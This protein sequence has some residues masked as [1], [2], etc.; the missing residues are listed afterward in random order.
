[1]KEAMCT[2]VILRRPGHDWPMILAANRDEMTDR[3]WRAPG[4]HWPDRNHLIAG[5]DETAGGTWLALND[6]QIVATV[7][8]RSGSLG[9]TAHK[10]SR[11][12]LPLEAVDH[13]EAG[14]AAEALAQIEPDSYRNFNMVIADAFEASW[15]RGDGK[16][17][18]AHQIPD[19]LSMITAHDL[20]DAEASEKIRNHLPRFRAAAPPDPDAGDWGAWQSLMAALCVEGENGFGTISSSLIGLPSVEKICARPRWLFCPGRPG[21]ATWSAVDLSC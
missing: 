17:V 19:G 2:V 13:A 18:T 8:N 3:S 4:R 15:I 5:L 6:D 1:M 10:R 7:L 20:N 21:V 16:T 11:G 9:P 12:E 14:V